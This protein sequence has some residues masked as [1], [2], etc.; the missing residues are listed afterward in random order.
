MIYLDHNARGA[1]RP[2]ARA[3]ILAALDE[4]GNASSVHGAGRAVRARIEN[5]RAQVATLAGAK[6]SSVVFTS[7][8]TEA[9]ALALRGAVQGAQEAGERITRLFVSAIEHDSVRANAAHLAESAPGLRASE[10]PVNGHGVVEPEAVRRALMEGK[11]RALVSIMTAN[12]ETG[13]VQ[14]LGEIVAAAKSGGALVH[15]DAVQ[16]AGRITLDFDGLD[17]DYM[18]LSAHKLGAPPGAGALLLKDDAPYAAL[19]AGGG[20]EMRR[21][22]GTENAPAIAGF[23]AAAGTLREFA[24]EAERVRALRD[25]FERKLREMAPDAVIFGE[26]APRLPNTSNFAIPGMV[27][28]TAVIALDLDGVA[29]SSGSACSSGKVAPSHVLAAMGV[30]EALARCALRVSFGWNSTENDAER[31]L[32]ALARHR[33]RARAKAA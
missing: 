9:N 18:A 10:I 3:A 2:E 6:P 4:A 13:V 17:I 14:P 12:N 5:A 15:I 27:A 24:G 1:L 23:G 22:A 8:G 29:V 31:A 20:Q 26:N 33:A 28:E 7:G 21:R 30:A 25:G 11:G 19:I 32:A 16:A